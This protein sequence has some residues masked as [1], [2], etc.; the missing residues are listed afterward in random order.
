MFE[1]NTW[2]H[3]VPTAGAE[4]ADG[5]AACRGTASPPATGTADTLVVETSGFNGYTRLDTAGHPHSKQLKLT[6]TFRPVDAQHDR[7]HHDRA[8]PEGLHPGLDERAH[9]GS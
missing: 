8:R 6:N 2:F 1:Q 3:W 5:H 4:V 9:A 7:A